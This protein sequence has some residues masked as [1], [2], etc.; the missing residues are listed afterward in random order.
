MSVKNQLVLSVSSAIR[1]LMAQVQPADI[2]FRLARYMPKTR[3]VS[4]PGQFK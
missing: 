3:L 1:K 4:M 2:N